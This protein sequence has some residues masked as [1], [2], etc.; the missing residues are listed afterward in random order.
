MSES[1]IGPSIQSFQHGE[2]GEGQALS[3]NVG[4]T[5]RPIAAR[6]SLT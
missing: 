4:S 2:L 6:I 1:D 3:L 5:L